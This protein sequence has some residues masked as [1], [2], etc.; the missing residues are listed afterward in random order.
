V[1]ATVPK[2]PDVE[3]L[4]LTLEAIDEFAQPEVQPKPGDV[5]SFDSALDRLRA[6]GHGGVVE[7]AAAHDAAPQPRA[8]AQQTAS[9]RREAAATPSA[10]AP[11]PAT[12]GCHALAP[13]RA[14]MGS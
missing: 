11:A 4:E 7:P 10:A 9:P 13:I 1:S 8:D 2:G 3:A 12:V 5:A 6:A 14:A